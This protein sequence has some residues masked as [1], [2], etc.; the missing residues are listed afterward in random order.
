MP[1]LRGVSDHVFL[2]SKLKDIISQTGRKNFHYI[3]VDDPVQGLKE[4]EL[5]QK[6]LAAGI[7]CSELAYKKADGQWVVYILRK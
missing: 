5:I 2:F 7:K 4:E 3:V 6:I 1:D